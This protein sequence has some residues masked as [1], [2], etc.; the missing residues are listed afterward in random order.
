MVRVLFCG[1]NP[2]IRR[3]K[4]VHVI[5]AS[6]EVAASA[7]VLA[8]LVWLFFSFR[9][10]PRRAF[11]MLCLALSSGMNTCPLRISVGRALKMVV[12]LSPFQPTGASLV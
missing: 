8:H 9:F 7:A 5:K 10:S 1:S 12:W 4:F 11:I 2:A 6:P 3:R